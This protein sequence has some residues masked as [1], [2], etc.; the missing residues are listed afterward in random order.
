MDRHY[1]LRIA[2]EFSEGLSI[3]RSA[4]VLQSIRSVLELLP[5]QPE[6]GSPDIRPVLTARYGPGLRKLVVSTFVI[7][8]RF[9]SQ[10]IDV[11]AI[12]HGP[13]II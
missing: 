1:Q 4:R 8:Y 12:I 2:E 7:I 10:T 5:T 9:D 3:I 6:I 11:L 13:S